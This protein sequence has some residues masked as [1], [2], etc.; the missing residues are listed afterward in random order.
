[1]GARKQVKTTEEEILKEA[2]AAQ[3]APAKKAKA[4]PSKEKIRGKKY[5]ETAGKVS[6]DAFPL[7]GAVKQVKTLSY[8]SFDASVDAHIKL[9]VEPGNQEQSIRTFVSLPHG[10]GKQVKVLVFAESALVAKAKE[11]GADIIGDEDLIDEIAAGKIPAVDAVIA[12]PSFMPKIAKAARVLGPKGLMPTPKTGTVTDDPAKAVGEIKKGKVELKT[13]DQPLIHI[14]IGKVSFDEQK[15][16][17][18]LK[19]V[20]EEL[21]QVRPSKIKGVYIQSVHLAP[22]MGP[23]VKVD[24]AS[25]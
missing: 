22:T 17:D 13:G 19:A 8:A 18:N 3:P 20:I 7:A 24:L 21:N 12:T 10:T 2:E 6:A 9:G 1:M 15:L 4:K 5:K 25:L 11:A 16:I 23:S 14:S